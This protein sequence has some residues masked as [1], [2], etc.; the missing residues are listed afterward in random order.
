MGVWGSGL[1]ANDCSCD[2][3]DSYIEYLREQLSNEE[4]YKKT[5]ENNSE[6]IGNEDEPFFWYALADTQWEKGRLMPE[7]KEKALA[8]IEAGGGLELW[9]ESAN[10]GTGWKK[11]LQKLK[12]KL[13]SP[14]PKEKKIRKTVAFETNPWNINDIY[15][16]QFHGPD[17]KESGLWGK[18][19][20]L[21]K[22]DE[23]EYYD[24]KVYLRIQVFDR[25]FTKLPSLADLN[26]IRL[27]PL[28]P[29]P[30]QDRFLGSCI[31]MSSI[32]VAYKKSDYPD[33]YLTFIGNKMGLANNWRQRGSYCSWGIIEDCLC[34]YYRDW[35]NIEY[36]AIADGIY[37][38]VD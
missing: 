34:T 2:V 13:E 35:Q 26:G 18:Y 33:K 11:T 29:Y 24:K 31:E 3:R 10:G 1:Y 32:M 22:I 21:Q 30:I 14:T 9:E 23:D 8:W 38:Y 6:Y 27:L 4:A 36:K 25:L 19:I 17:S 16:Y 20:F 28:E 37:G 15:A 5:M 7:V 12:L